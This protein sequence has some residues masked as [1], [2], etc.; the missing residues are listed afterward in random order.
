M[1]LEGLFIDFMCLIMPGTFKPI[2]N[3]MHQEL[4][5]YQTRL[6]ALRRASRDDLQRLLN[7]AF[8]TYR[9][10]HDQERARRGLS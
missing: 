7:Q 2:R 8:P 3:K 4:D 1:F 10:H 6:A 5:E 9:H